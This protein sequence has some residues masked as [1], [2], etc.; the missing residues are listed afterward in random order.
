MLDAF[1][2]AY[3]SYADR[4]AFCEKNIRV[5]L[6]WAY[7]CTT[8]RELARQVDVTPQYLCYLK[9]RRNKPSPAFLLRLL[10]ISDQWA[11]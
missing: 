3:E 5:I 1:R 10:E 7:K 6:A 11:D 9:N 4:L 2:Q 8:Q